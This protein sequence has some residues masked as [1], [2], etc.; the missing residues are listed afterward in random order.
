M[1]KEASDE[2]NDV[3]KIHADVFLFIV[4]TITGVTMLGSGK[5]CVK[6]PDIVLHG[7]RVA[8]QHAFV[9]RIANEAM[10]HPISEETS[11]DGRHIKGPTPLHSGE[12][13]IIIK[14]SAKNFVLIWNKFLKL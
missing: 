14:T 13:V 8:P 5:G 3:K 11:I 7:T 6:P 10:L 1:F 12:H 4:I 2:E 9:E